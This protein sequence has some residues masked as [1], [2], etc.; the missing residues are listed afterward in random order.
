MAGFRRSKARGEPP[1]PPP[2]ATECEFIASCARRVLSAL[3]CSDYGIARACMVQVWQYYTFD[4]PTSCLMTLRANV[5][6]A[7]GVLSFTRPSL[8]LGRKDKTARA[9]TLTRRGPTP[10]PPSHP[11]AVLARYLRAVPPSSK[12]LFH[13]ATDRDPTRFATPADLLAVA[14]RAVNAAPDPGRQ[15]HAH[16]RGSTTAAHM[17]GVH[18]PTLHQHADWAPSSSVF[19]SN[20]WVSDLPRSPLAAAYFGDLLD[21]PRF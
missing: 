10:L 13:I 17:L 9:V 5:R 16:R 20:Y 2:G 11:I 4:R 12:Y 14:A 3:T 19:A 18:T 15:P 6:I 1:K 21:P 7:E 8:A